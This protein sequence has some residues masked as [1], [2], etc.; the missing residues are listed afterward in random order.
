MPDRLSAAVSARL[1]ELY[2]DDRA[3]GYRVGDIRGAI[4]LRRPA[5]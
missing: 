5:P 4:T 3:V 1:K 2:P